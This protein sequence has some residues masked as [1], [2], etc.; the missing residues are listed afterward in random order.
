V[1]LHYVIDGYLD[2]DGAELFPDLGDL[3]ARGQRI[4][5][6]VAALL[7]DGTPQEAVYVRR[8]FKSLKDIHDEALS[9]ANDLVNVTHYW[10]RR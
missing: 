5:D 10:D 3:K 1:A 7:H 8:N 4:R 9:I 6:L 2:R